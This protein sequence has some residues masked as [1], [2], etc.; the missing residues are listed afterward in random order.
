M[1]DHERLTLKSLRRVDSSIERY[2]SVAQSTVYYSYDARTKQ[3]V[4]P[5]TNGYEGALFICERQSDPKYCLI[6]L[7]RASAQHFVLP[8]QPGVMAE[9]RDDNYIFI[10]VTGQGAVK[11]HGFWFFNNEEKAVIGEQLKS[12]LS[13]PTPSA[14]P[15]PLTPM[16]TRH[17]GSTGSRGGPAA[18]PHGPMITVTPTRGGE[19]AVT[20]V[21]EGLLHTPG[22]QGVPYSREKVRAMLSAMLNN[23]QF[24]DTVVRHLNNALE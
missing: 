23:D 7:N 15:Q 24:I 17:G 6:I 13:Q 20:R 3:W 21:M 5:T 14:I 1:N 18:S 11:T 2:L 16:M 9:V 8:I 10:R 4:K 22:P 19:E 12:I